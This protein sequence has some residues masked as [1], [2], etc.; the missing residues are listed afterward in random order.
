MTLADPLTLVHGKLTCAGRGVA[1]ID[2]HVGSLW[3]AEVHA[4]SLV[5]QRLALSTAQW[6]RT[7]ANGSIRCA[8]KQL[9][10]TDDE[11]RFSVWVPLRTETRLWVLSDRYHTIWR[12]YDASTAPKVVYIDLT[13]LCDSRRVH[14]E[15]EGRHADCVIGAAVRIVDTEDPTQ[16][17]LPVQR[18]RADMTL[19]TSQTIPGRLYAIAVFVPDGGSEFHYALCAFCDGSRVVIRSRH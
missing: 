3:G 18:V 5:D 12:V 11:G 4:P 14:L 16:P 7:T 15:I 19:S 2:V 1:G 17:E 6:I 9:V 13:P 8:M 10:T